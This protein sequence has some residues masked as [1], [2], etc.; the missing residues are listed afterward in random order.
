M[1]HYADPL[2]PTMSPS[3]CWRKA[4]DSDNPL[5]FPMTTK[6]SR[7]DRYLS[8]TLHINRRDVKPLLAAGRVRVN[9]AIARDTDLLINQ[10]ATI[11]VDDKALPCVQAHYL[12]LNKPAGI[13]SATKDAS[14]STVFAFLDMTLHAGLHIV[15]RLDKN[16]TGLLLLT[17]DGEWSRSLMAPDKHVEKSYIVGVKHA[18]SD[19]CVEAFAR[20]MHFPFEDI[21][22]LPARLEVLAPHLARVTLTEGRYH[23]IKRMFGRFRNP[24]LSLHRTQI[25]TITLDP[26]LQPGTYRALHPR[27]LECSAVSGGRSQP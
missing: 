10:F 11:V 8:N 23:Q 17:N 6:R 9:G 14:Q 1:R 13:L 16:S 25:G 15:G 24:V 18:I 21:V 19:E 20:G 5:R 27:E 4:E 2:L 26:E 7:L 22:T 3:R 12:M